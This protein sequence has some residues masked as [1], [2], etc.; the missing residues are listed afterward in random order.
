MKL[1]SAAI[2][3]FLFI[4]ITAAS[5]QSTLQNGIWRGVLKTATGNNLPFNFEVTGI[6]GAKQLAVMNGDERLKSN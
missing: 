4:L 3:V 2:A 5:A 6:A 1:R